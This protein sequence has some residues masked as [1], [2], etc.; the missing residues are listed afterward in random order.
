MALNKLAWRRPM[1]VRMKRADEED[2]TDF[3]GLA[4][5]KQSMEVEQRMRKERS[6][7]IWG[8]NVDG[9]VFVVAVVIAVIVVRAWSAA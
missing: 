9:I 3:T 4:S 8:L 7:S 6:E 2:D 1:G 5:V